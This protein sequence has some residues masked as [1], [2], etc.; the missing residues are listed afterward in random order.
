M[1]T[2]AQFEAFL[3][4]DRGY[5]VYMCGERDDQ[6]N[7]PAETNPYDMGSNEYQEWEDG[8]MA[9]VIETQDNP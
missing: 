6:P 9:A 5:V 4:F 3:P 1:F 7:I 8:Q 2:E